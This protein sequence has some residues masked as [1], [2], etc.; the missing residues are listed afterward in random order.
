MAN[1]QSSI[2][3]SQRY[4]AGFLTSP[5]LLWLLLIQQDLPYKHRQLEW[6]PEHPELLF[7]DLPLEV[8]N[9]PRFALSFGERAQSCFNP[10]AFTG[11]VCLCSEL[12]VSGRHS[13]V[14]IKYFW[15]FSHPL[16]QPFLS[17]QMYH[18]ARK[19]YYSS[20][21]LEGLWGQSWVD[22]KCLTRQLC[23]NKF[24]FQRFIQFIYSLRWH[25]SQVWAILH[26]C[27]K[28]YHRLRV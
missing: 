1:T 25:C 15:Y 21:C 11:D 8:P 14:Q 9:M 12:C 27:V 10:I 4:V 17:E 18:F 13:S 5:S 24:Q 16:L 23:R 26:L 7:P 3:C 2:C 28:P 20:H 22:L 19:L 6:N